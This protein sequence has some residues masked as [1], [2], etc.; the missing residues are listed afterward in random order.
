MNI[1]TRLLHLVFGVAMLYSVG[2]P[3]QAQ[4]STGT[5]KSG[6]AAEEGVAAAGE[7]KTRNIEIT[8][9]DYKFTPS[10]FTVPEGAKV[11]V[12]LTNKAH[13]P[14][15]IQ[16]HFPG[17]HTVKL[18]KDIGFNESASLEF[19]APGPGTYSFKCPVDLHSTFGMKGKMTVK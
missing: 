10:E 11:T 13:K 15:N 14:H 6:G 1:D 8:A 12:T 3:L 4:E 7:Q 17:G 18:P 5:R 16:F 2:M 9:S 19:T